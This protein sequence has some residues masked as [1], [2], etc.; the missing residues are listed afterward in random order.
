MRNT[1]DAQ[2]HAFYWPIVKKGDKCQHHQERKAMMRILPA[3][4]RANG[5][6]GI[7]GIGRRQIE[8]WFSRCVVEGIAPEQM[9]ED[10]Q[11]LCRFWERLGRSGLPPPP[12][13]RE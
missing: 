7:H 6:V 4:A 9:A 3:I 10:Y 12:S 5:I 2:I 1:L 8:R 11:W 13:G